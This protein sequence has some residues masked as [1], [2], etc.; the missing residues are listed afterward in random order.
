MWNGNLEAIVQRNTHRASLQKG[1]DETTSSPASHGKI[2][3][4]SWY[5]MTVDSVISQHSWL[6]LAVY[7]FQVT[8]HSICL[9]YKMTNLTFYISFGNGGESDVAKR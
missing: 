4:P 8:K 3:K 7:Q 2:V 5:I 6:P 1:L 9:N